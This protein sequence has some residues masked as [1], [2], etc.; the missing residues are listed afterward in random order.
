METLIKQI[1]EATQ[2]IEKLYNTEKLTPEILDKHFKC[3]EA[4]CSELLMVRQLLRDETQRAED[5][6]MDRDDPEVIDSVRSVIAG[7]Q[8][9]LKDIRELLETVLALR[10]AKKLP[11]KTEYLI[12]DLHGRQTQ[13]QDIPVPRPRLPRWVRN[14]L[15]FAQIFMYMGVTAAMV[16]LVIVL[17]S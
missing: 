4:S 11:Y 17:L 10:D 9:L 6:L 14:A 3:I 5:V 13:H 2:E 7:G 15:R 16:F 8:V 1:S 12:K